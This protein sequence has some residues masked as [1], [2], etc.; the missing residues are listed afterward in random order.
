MHSRCSRFRKKKT[1]LTLLCNIVT[2]YEFDFNAV[3]KKKKKFVDYDVLFD[4]L[5]KGPLMFCDIERLAGVPHSSVQQVI[6]TLSI[7]YP[8]WSPERG[9]YK[10]MTDEDLYDSPKDCKD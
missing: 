1:K 5:K 9:V 6:T 7:K 4:A 2:A 8:V 10:L 3:V